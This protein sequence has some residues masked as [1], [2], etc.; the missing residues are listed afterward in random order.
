MPNT[1]QGRSSAMNKLRNLFKQSND[2]RGMVLITILVVGMIVTFVGLSLAD[3]TISQYARTS[4]NVYRANA[5]LVAEAGIEETL[6]RLNADNSFTGF[7]SEQSFYDDEDRGRAT[8]QTVVSDGPNGEKILE[9]TGK[10]YRPNSEE[11]VSTR[12]I[13]VTLVGTA[14]P[15][16]SVVAGA[17]GLI[18]GGAAKIYNSDVHV[19]GTISMAGST[20]IGSNA[21][22]ADVSVAYANC[23]TGSNPGPTYPQVCTTGQPI[24]I[25][26]W[27]N[28]SIIGTVCATNQT[29][30]K[31]P[32][33]QWN[34]NDPQIRAGTSG[35]SGLV[36]GCIAEVKPMPTYDRAAHISRMTTTGSMSSNTYNCNNWISGAEFKRT[37]PANLKLT[38]NVNIASAC[39]LTITGDVYITGNFSVGGGATIRVAD[40]LGSTVPRIVVDGTVDL[41]GGGKVLENASGTSAQVI[42]YKSAA[43]CSPSCTNVTGT[44]LKK[45]QEQQNVTVDGGG[46]FAGLAVWAYWSKVKISGSGLVGSVTGQKID[47][48]GAGNITFGTTL[49]SGTT[50]WT[51]RSYQRTFEHVE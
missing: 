13:Q 22:P 43:S 15:V 48:S 1:R 7:G 45:S 16:P 34:N 8:Y 17:G 5:T 23:P 32:E 25:P 30:S 12:S 21:K 29:Q 39:D 3:L 11:L 14:A 37:W 10:T 36:P 24:Y 31:F 41:G 44:D 38:G 6:H 46:T 50:T 42:S 4:E 49:S 35:G 9:S 51:I 26:D 33:S 47:M 28:S 27:N 20:Q 19:N 2:Q 40:S 18:L